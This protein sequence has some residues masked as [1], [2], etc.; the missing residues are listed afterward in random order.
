MAQLTEQEKLKAV[1]GIIIENYPDVQAIYLFGSYATEDQWPD[2]DIDLAM[3]L[4]PQ[5]AKSVSLLE[6]NSF[7]AAISDYMRKQVDLINIRQV[8]TVFQKEIIATGRILY[9]AMQYAVD[10]FE[11]LVMS[12]YQKLNEERREILDD[13]LRTGR[14]Y[15]V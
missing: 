2:S 4:P 10:E 1:P 3:L 15:R 9:C 7:S 8:S 6:L 13:F 14:A 11:M 5:K 12:Y